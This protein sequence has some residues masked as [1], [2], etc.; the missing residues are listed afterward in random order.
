[1]NTIDDEMVER[2]AQLL[3]NL[4]SNY[5]YQP[6]L[7]TEDQINEWNQLRNNNI[8]IANCLRQQYYLLEEAIYKKEISQN[9]Y[10]LVLQ[11]VEQYKARWE[12]F[13]VAEKYV[14]IFHSKLKILNAYIEKLPHP[15]KN[16][17]HK[18]VHKVS[19]EKYP[20]E[21]AYD[22]FV[23]TLREETDEVFRCSLNYYVVPIKKW[24]EAT[25][26][27]T[28]I[29]DKGKKDGI[30]PKLKN[31]EINALKNKLGLD[32]LGFSWLGMTLLVCQLEAPKDKL[33]REKLIAYNQTLKEALSIA[34]KASQKVRSF[35]WDKGKVIYA[36]GAG[37]IYPRP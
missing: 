17:W 20:F 27:M 2:I 36:S 12:L 14:K 10:Y 9:K 13:Q 35:V 25:T 28:E 7:L 19:L 21:S 11:M 5:L 4:P 37:G 22:L 26:Q 8:L 18:L 6:D 31:G 1:M 23:E 33:L 24:R 15:M 16:L 3:E 30:Y 32:K 34:V 29:L